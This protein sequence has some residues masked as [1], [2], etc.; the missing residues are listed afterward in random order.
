MIQWSAWSRRAP[1]WA[2]KIWREVAAF[3]VVGAVAFVV[4]TA[5]FN[6]LILGSA[7]DG[8]TRGANPVVA[9]VLATVLAMLVSW[10]GNRYWTYRDRRGPLDRREV[11]LFVGVNLVGM[12]VTA[13]P[14]YVSHSLLG[15]GSPLS[16]NVA[17]LVGW[18]AATVVRFVA[19]RS[20]VFVS[21]GEDSTHVPGTTERPGATLRNA[22]RRDA[23]WPWTLAVIAAVCGYLVSVVFHPGY[24]SSD[25]L[26][27]L[28]QTLGETPVEDWH[29]PVM[30]VLWKV[31]IRAT[32]T[33]ATMA[34]LQAALLWA[35]LWL[36]ARLTWLK[37]RSRNLSLL[38][39]SLGLFPYVLNFTGVVWKDVQ[40]AYVLLATVAI[41]LTAREL[42][43]DRT[44]TRW[45][46][47]VVGVLLLAYAILVRKN[48][49]PAVIPVFALLV[50]ALW[51]KPGR[52]RWLVSTG[53]L[54]AVTAG[55]SAGVNAVVDPIATRQYAQIPL[56]DLTHVLTPG[57][58]RS[59]ADRAGADPA[60][61]DALATTASVCQTKKIPSDA[62]FHCYPR[63]TGPAPMRPE[64]VDVMVDMWIEQMPRHWKA[65]TQY[66][67]KL[68]NRLIFQT[69]YTFQ[70]GTRAK[71]ELQPVPLREEPANDLLKSSLQYYVQGFV[72]DT[73][74]LFKGWFWLAVALVLTLRRRWIG[75]Y[76]REIRLL[77]ASTILYLLAYLPTAPESSYRYVYWPA[78]AGTISLM[79]IGYAHVVR[80]RAGTATATTGDATAGSAA[81]VATPAP[82][83]APGTP[84]TPGGPVTQTL[85]PYEVDQHS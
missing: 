81:A 14:L 58:I 12:A 21:P 75:P 15:L 71:P 83:P 70:D 63:K 55:A 35:S 7:S 47:L 68:F 74:I 59:A 4:E 22:W 84:D 19:Y 85:H 10:F 9:S 80:R 27:Q 76:T 24:L 54:I 20:L 16:D 53:V 60:F 82:A 77:G 5:S 79:M 45:V 36:L 49:F 39:L 26:S 32:G 78:I 42:P 73:P 6:L 72:K 67:V 25:S 3:G 43:A 28:R 56:D 65:Y 50:L 48:A 40:M 34:A 41:A 29:P 30:V 57:Q 11:T 62:L 44:R 18:A 13:L 1:S 69:N 8:G 37:T 31:L 33:L 23:L 64:N 66:R 51:P 17:R 52:R 38:T 46:L 2:R 61:R